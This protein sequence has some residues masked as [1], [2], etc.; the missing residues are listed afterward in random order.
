[1]MGKP[2]PGES[3]IQQQENVRLNEHL[4]RT[5]SDVLFSAA[6]VFPNAATSMQAFRG[7]TGASCGGNERSTAQ[8]SRAVQSRP[9]GHIC[10]WRHVWCTQETTEGSSTH[11]HFNEKTNN[12]KRNE[13]AN[14]TSYLT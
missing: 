4:M 6:D 10:Q 7:R 11:D 14:E 8:H 1:M 12:K 5:I 9:N 13:K 2:I 3:T